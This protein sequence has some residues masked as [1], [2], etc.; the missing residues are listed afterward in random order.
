MNNLIDILA[1]DVNISKTER[2]ISAAG[3]IALII[4]GVLT[5]K[6]NKAAS[7]AELSTGAALLYRGASG[8]CP[9]NA[10]M[11]RNTAATELVED[12]KD[13]FNELAR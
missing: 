2:I 1:G 3:G 6:K 5:M 10:A 8:H 13:N 7:W 4:T 11:N 12:A 9:V